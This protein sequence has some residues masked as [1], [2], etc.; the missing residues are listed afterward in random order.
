MQ[1]N[2]YNNANLSAVM[3]SDDFDYNTIADMPPTSINS[4]NAQ[5]SPSDNKI[6]VRLPINGDECY[7]LVAEYLYLG[8]PVDTEA[9]VAGTSVLL[10]TG[11]VNGVRDLNLAEDHT[12]HWYLDTAA[13]TI[14]GGVVMGEYFYK[15]ET[16]EGDVLII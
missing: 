12:F 13:Q 7:S 3:F 6:V 10:M 16:M 5:N 9:T 8:P 4:I 1:E 14:E 11:I 15:F 2:I